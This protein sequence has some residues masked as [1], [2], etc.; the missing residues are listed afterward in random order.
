MSTRVLIRVRL[1]RELVKLEELLFVG[2]PL[3]ETHK[4]TEDFRINV[5]G[6]L[7]WLKKLDGQPVDDDE[8][9]RGKALVG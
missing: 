7:P 3:Y 4:P 2:N 1:Q 8:R 6:R 9:E 5:A